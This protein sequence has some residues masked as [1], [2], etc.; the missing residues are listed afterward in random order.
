[1]DWTGECYKMSAVKAELLRLGVPLEG[2]EAE[3]RVLQV[4]TEREVAYEFATMLLHVQFPNRTAFT[5][6]C[7]GQSLLGG[8]CSFIDSFFYFIIIIIYIHCIYSTIY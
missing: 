1:M 8:I 6:P 4:T 2:E 5:L 3:N 7:P